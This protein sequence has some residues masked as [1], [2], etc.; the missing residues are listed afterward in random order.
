MGKMTVTCQDWRPLRR[1]TL[2]GFATIRIDEMHLVIHDVAI[3]EKDG[4]QWAQPPAKPQVKDGLVIKDASGK[5]QYVNIME[6]DGR[7]V[8]D[9]F[10]RAVVSAVLAREPRAFSAD[11]Q[12]AAAQQTRAPMDAEIPF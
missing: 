3:H 9:A 2:H 12:S 10:S 1:N 4:R 5:A 11:D 8:R 6:F 7:E